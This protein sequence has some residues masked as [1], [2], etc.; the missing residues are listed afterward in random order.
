MDGWRSLVF[1]CGGLL[2]RKGGT[3]RMEKAPRIKDLASGDRGHFFLRHEK[4]D[5]Y[6][7]NSVKSGSSRYRVTV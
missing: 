3:R 7:K 2:L 1:C 4:G 5:S 6:V